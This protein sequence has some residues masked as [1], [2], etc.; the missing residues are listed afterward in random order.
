MF[1]EGKESDGG[2]A[3]TFPAVHAPACSLVPEAL[4]IHVHWVGRSVGPL[5]AASAAIWRGREDAADIALVRA[6]LHQTPVRIRHVGL[7]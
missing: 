5:I 1:G 7:E 4:A 3:S 6:L 2:L